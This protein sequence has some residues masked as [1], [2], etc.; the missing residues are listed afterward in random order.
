MIYSFARFYNKAR[1]A[2][3]ACA[4]AALSTGS[5]YSYVFDCEGPS[6]EAMI[7]ERDYEQRE[8]EA[9]F[10]RCQRGEGSERDYEKADRYLDDNLS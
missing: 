1:V 3:L 8:N 6:G 5:L 7:L 10:D 4:I 2:V 9:A